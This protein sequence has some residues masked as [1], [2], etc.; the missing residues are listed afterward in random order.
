MSLFCGKA[1]LRAY[2]QTAS[3]VFLAHSS[4]SSCRIIFCLTAVPYMLIEL[5]NSWQLR[6]G[7]LVWIIFFQSHFFCSLIVGVEVNSVTGS[8]TR[9]QNT[10]YWTP[11]EGGS[12]RHR[13][14]Y[15]IRHNIHNIQTS[16]P[17]AIFEPAIPTTERPQF[18]TSDR[19]TMWLN[20]QA[21][22]AGDLDAE[23]NY[24]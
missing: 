9:T 17:K 10:L 2:C 8:H 22:P 11:L 5:T 19:A 13:G 24:R 4:A 7:F 1:S 3:A 14:L 23:T 16:I 18:C 12:D 21:K 15:L 6:H 20:F